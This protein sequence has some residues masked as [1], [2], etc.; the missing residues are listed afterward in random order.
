[1]MQPARM[2][3]LTI[4]ASLFLPGQN[5]IRLR[6][7]CVPVQ[8]TRLWVSGAFMSMHACVPPLE[9]KGSNS[10]TNTQGL[11]RIA[12]YTSNAITLCQCNRHTWSM[13]TWSRGLKAIASST[14]TATKAWRRNRHTHGDVTVRHETLR[15]LA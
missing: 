10:D 6:F 12:P 11:V 4:S 3:A 5:S 8:A 15:L 7:R 9:A 2:T 14:P 13:H 1:M